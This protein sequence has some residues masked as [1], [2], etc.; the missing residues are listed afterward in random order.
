MVHK[1]TN[2]EPNSASNSAN[3]KLKIGSI[4][5]TETVDLIRSSHADANIIIRIPLVEFC[6]IQDEL[7][8]VE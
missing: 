7:I 3:K 5:A 8:F 1:Q 2:N 4:V 6:W